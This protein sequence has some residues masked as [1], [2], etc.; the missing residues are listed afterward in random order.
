VTRRGESC[1]RASPLSLGRWSLGTAR[2]SAR[3]AIYFVIVNAVP[4][5]IGISPFVLQRTVNFASLSA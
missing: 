4:F 5:G 3:I 1:A 2:R